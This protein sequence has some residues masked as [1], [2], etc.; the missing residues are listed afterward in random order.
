MS[1][2]ANTK[3]HLPSVIEHPRPARPAT[4]LTNP[5]HSPL[6]GSVGKKP[7]APP[8]D[9]RIVGLLAAGGSQKLK[10]LKREARVQRRRAIFIGILCVIALLIAWALFAK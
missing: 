2:D 5:R 4:S 6:T 8:H 7:Q 1:P 3:L 10:P 9:P